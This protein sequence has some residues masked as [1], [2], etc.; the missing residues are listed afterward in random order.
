MNK[1]ELIFE[2]GHNFHGNI[3]FAKKMLDAVKEC[4]G[5]LAKLQL[6][7][8]TK[9]GLRPQESDV[10]PE[11]EMGQINFEEFKELKEYA[12]SI[13]IELFASAFDPE[14][15]E[16]CERVGVKRH[17]LASRS[18]Y[19]TETA[20]AMVDTNKPIIASLGMYKWD[21]LIILDNENIDFLYCVSDYPAT[22]IE[23]E[24][25]KRFFKQRQPN[26]S[27]IANNPI[28]EY[29]FG[30]TGFSDHTI[31]IE[32]AKEAIRR[33]ATI[34]EKHFTLDKRLPGC[35]QSCSANPE[36]MKELQN[37]INEYQ[38]QN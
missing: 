30:Y 26:S 6:Y 5:T 28:V 8:V 9:L 33:G 21:K 22:I 4:G 1:I 19:D 14:R 11:L 24:F 35:D 7:D 12:D 17:K 20:E 38:E 27:D 13:G 25:P 23:E 2:I 34:I 37:F 29:I 32:W 15:V 16:W 36:E 18:I 3:R 31:G 10:Y